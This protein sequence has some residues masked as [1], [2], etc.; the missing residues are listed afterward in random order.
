V[1]TTVIVSPLVRASERTANLTSF[2]K[3][4]MASSPGSMRQVSLSR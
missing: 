4:I 1:R 2:Q 3:G